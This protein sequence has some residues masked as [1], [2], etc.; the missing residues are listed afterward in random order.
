MKSLIEGLLAYSR[1]ST[2]QEPV[3]SVDLAAVVA[4]VL[5]DLEI[6]LRETRAKV[7]VGAL[8][9]IFADPWTCGSCFRT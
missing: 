2:S 3:A 8:P 5:V 1:V 7:G 6:P 4:E 9:K